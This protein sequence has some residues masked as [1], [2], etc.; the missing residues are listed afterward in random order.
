MSCRTPSKAMRTHRDGQSSARAQEGFQAGRGTGCRAGSARVWVNLFSPT[1][2]PSCPLP[3]PPPPA[4]LP[5][6]QW[7]LQ[8]LFKM[9]VPSTQQWEAPPLQVK[10]CD[11]LR[12]EPPLPPR[13]SH[14]TV[15]SV[16]CDAPTGGRG[17]PEGRAQ[18]LCIPE[19]VPPAGANL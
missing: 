5:L 17:L 11:L 15:T 10:P 4:L 18:I 16:Q 1:A 19:P 8:Y 12:V 3:Q 14:S 7:H 13:Q 6:R 2:Q 9:G